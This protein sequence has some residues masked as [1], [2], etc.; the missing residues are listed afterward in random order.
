MQ[1]E[2]I[3]EYEA[4][5]IARFAEGCL[6]NTTIPLVDWNWI[7]EKYRVTLKDPD[8]WMC[9]VISSKDPNINGWIIDYLYH[10]SGCHCCG[11]TYD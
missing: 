8:S 6:Q 11:Y 9:E 4:R 3:D 7:I 10:D 2:F 5:K 1:P